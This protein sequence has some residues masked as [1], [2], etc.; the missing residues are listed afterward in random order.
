MN[1]EAF[2]SVTMPLLYPSFFK[3]QRGNFDKFS[4]KF[5]IH[6]FIFTK[7]GS[8]RLN[9]GCVLPFCLNFRRTA[10]DP[11]SRTMDAEMLLDALQKSGACLFHTP[12]FCIMLQPYSTACR[13]QRFLLLIFSLFKNHKRNHCRNNN[14]R[15]YAYN[16]I[17]PQRAAL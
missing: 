4:L 3:S 10:A 5:R 6:S 13:L 14:N 2:C 11:L 12:L 8:C 1:T 17:N 7:Q 9:A 16:H 15:N